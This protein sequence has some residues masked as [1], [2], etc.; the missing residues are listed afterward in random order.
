MRSILWLIAGFLV[1]F[2]AHVTLPYQYVSGCR[3]GAL[4]DFFCSLTS[5][6]DPAIWMIFLPF[7]LACT[8]YN[9]VLCRC[10]LSGLANCRLF[11]WPIAFVAAFLSLWVE[12]FWIFNTFGS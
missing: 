1:V 6:L 10:G 7:A 8:G 2:G 11:R 5:T 9:Y 4:P 12:L 3:T